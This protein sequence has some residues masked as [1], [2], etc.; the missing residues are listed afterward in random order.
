VRAIA[1]LRARCVGASDLV[2]TLPGG[3]ARS[4]AWSAYALETYGDALLEACTRDGYVGVETAHVVRGSFA[5]AGICVDVARGGPG[6]VPPTLPHWHTVPRSHE[7][8]VGMRRTLELLHAYLAYELGSGDAEVAPID[9]QLVIESPTFFA[10][11][12]RRV[13]ARGR[14]VLVSL[15]V[16][17]MRI[18]I[19]A[20]FTL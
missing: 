13:R 7:Q 19:A 8:L 2:D 14:T 16:L 18:L 20:I 15:D 5:L 9:E 1:P 17:A 12:G 10:F 6:E 4:A 11:A 3:P